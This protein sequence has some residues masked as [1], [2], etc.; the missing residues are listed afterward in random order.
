MDFS[1]WIYDL[2]GAVALFL[3][4]LPFLAL[5]VGLLVNFM[6]V[7]IQDIQLEKDYFRKLSPEDKKVIEDYKENTSYIRVKRRLRRIKKNLN[8]DK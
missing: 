6:Y 2:F 1:Q 8:N 5:L 3:I 4:W 7:C